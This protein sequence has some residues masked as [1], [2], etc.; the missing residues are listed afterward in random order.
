MANW[1]SENSHNHSI[2][3]PSRDAEYYAIK[4]NDT[5]PGDHRMQERIL[6]LWLDYSFWSYNAGDRG[7]TFDGSGHCCPHHSFLA[8]LYGPV[9]SSSRNGGQR[10]TVHSASPHYWEWLKNRRRNAGVLIP[11]WTICALIRTCPP[12]GNYGF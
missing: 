4:D 3:V 12:R 10:P 5:G 2:D 1:S 8:Q 11:T 7:L 6:G 9:A